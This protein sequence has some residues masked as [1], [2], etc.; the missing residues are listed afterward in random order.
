MAVDVV[1]G[2]QWG[3]EGKGKVVQLLAQT[4][5]WVARFQGGANAGHTLL[6]QGKRLILHQVPSGIVE[7]RARCAI[8]NGV[9][10]DPLALVREISELEAIGIDVRARLRI[11]PFAHLVT[12]LHRAA[13][14]LTRQDHAIGT[15]GRGIGPAYA[16]K[17]ARSGLRVED[18]LSPAQLSGGLDGIWERLRCAHGLSDERLAYAA[19]STRSDLQAA[20]EEAG[21][22]ISPL[23]CD[24]SALLL[25][26]DDR[27]ERILAEGAQGALLDLDHGTYPFVTSSNTTIGGVCTGL[28][29]PPQRI[30]RVVGV[31]KAY[32]TR[33]GLGPFPTEMDSGIADGFRERAG[34]YGA[35]TGRPRRCGWYDAVLAHRCCRL[36]GVTELFVTK[37]DVLA[38][39][40]RLKI[41]HRYP[42]RA[43]EPSLAPGDGIDPA[44][45]ISSRRMDG[46]QP[47]YAEFD[48]WKEDLSAVGDYA[49]L[50]GSTRAY[51]EALGRWT[52]VPLGGISIGPGRDQVLTPPRG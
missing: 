26:A 52:G 24:V 38:G 40:E 34:E 30:G 14:T 16:E 48:G 6:L 47:E 41:A 29:L 23:I 2:C 42:A 18:L 4:A 33:V 19:G 13:E 11:S 21:R 1:L 44:G 28:G 20:L 22:V 25:D 31:V 8:G 43:T 49:G 37:L 35:T 32:A 15:T 10:L 12:P 7:A 27:G 39:I 3:D 9:V 46:V 50:P 51:V 17:A 45:W 36:N 5:D